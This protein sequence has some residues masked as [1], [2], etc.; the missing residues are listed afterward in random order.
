[1]KDFL[2]AFSS[3]AM[4]PLLF[5]QAAVSHLTRM[6]RIQQQQTAALEQQFAACLAGDVPAQKESPPPSDLDLYVGKSLSKSKSMTDLHT[7]MFGLV[8]LDFNPL[9]F[10][11]EMARR[12][13]FQDRIAHGMHTA[14]LFSGVLSE[15]TPWCAYL[16]QDLDFLA[17]VHPD[18][19]V[20]ATGVIEEITDRGVVRVALTCRNQK[21]ETVVRG[22][23]IV[24]KLKE[25]YQ[26]ALASASPV[27]VPSHG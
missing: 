15:L 3:M 2:E 21:G 26:P 27:A 19:V 16:H 23:A 25:M 11:P 8:S 17:P 1:V 5:S 12:S 13:R 6:L 18:E 14:S 20:T 4:L 9:H 24:K 7:L 22:H 10:N